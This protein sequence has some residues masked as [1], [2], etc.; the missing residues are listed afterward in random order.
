MVPR[1][2][3]KSRPCWPRSSSAKFKFHRRGDAL[4]FD[5]TGKTALIT[6]A[7]GGIGGAIARR[8]HGPGAT[9]VLSG[10]R[11]DAPTADRK[12]VV[13]GKSGSVRVDIGGRT[14]LHKNKH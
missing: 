14:K 11:A 9:V 12:R 3:R 13:E 1:R 5:L 2:R 7:S 6:G 8:L 4:M 10:T